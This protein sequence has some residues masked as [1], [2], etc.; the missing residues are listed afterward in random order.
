ME[1][2]VKVS[3]ELMK[4]IKEEYPE[5]TNIIDDDKG[6]AETVITN[7]LEGFEYGHY[8]LPEMFQKGTKMEKIHWD[9]NDGQ[10]KT[11]DGKC[12]YDKHAVDEAVR[13]NDGSI[14]YRM[15]GLELRIKSIEMAMTCTKDDPLPLLQCQAKGHGKWVYQESKTIFPKAPFF[16]QCKVFIFKCSAC[17]L[18][19]TKTEKELKPAEKEAL[20][21]LNLL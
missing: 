2:T 19:I 6:L 10:I 16:I 9:E 20:K 5:A 8:K 7:I 21:K 17:G 18:E 3:E 13:L 11:K 15:N 12:L 14:T 1:I 4:K